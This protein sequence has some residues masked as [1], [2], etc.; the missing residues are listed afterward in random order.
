MKSI[1]CAVVGMC[2]LLLI[3]AA[4]PPSYAASTLRLRGATAIER[5]MARFSRWIER[6]VE[7]AGFDR[8]EPRAAYEPNCVGLDPSGAPCA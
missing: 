8:D 4:T 5:P 3:F 7:W 1:R 6:L 2:V